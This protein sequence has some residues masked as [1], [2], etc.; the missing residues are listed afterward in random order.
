MGEETNSTRVKVLLS[1]GGGEGFNCRRV[2][3]L[4]TRVFVSTLLFV[5]W[6]SSRDVTV[7]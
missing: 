4:L 2:G 3:G 7:G 5:C 6:G 1:T